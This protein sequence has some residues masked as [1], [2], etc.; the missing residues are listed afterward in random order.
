[1]LLSSAADPARP[2]ALW[3]IEW[4]SAVQAQLL[5]KLSVWKVQLLD[6]FRVW[7][8]LVSGQAQRWTVQLSDKSGPF[9]SSSVGVVPSQLP[10]FPPLPPLEGLESLWHGSPFCTFHSMET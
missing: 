2:V 10:G 3:F 1:M 5:D 9:T 6:K 8:S 7:T 4:P